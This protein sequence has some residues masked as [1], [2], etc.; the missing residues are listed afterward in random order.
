M[1]E[2][3]IHIWFWWECQKKGDFWENNVMMNL[4]EIR[5]GG[6]DWILLAQDRDQ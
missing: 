6:M 4:R 1:R 2:R 5:W 3:G